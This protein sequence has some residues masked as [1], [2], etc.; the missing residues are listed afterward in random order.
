MRKQKIHSAPD[1]SDG[2]D[3]PGSFRGRINGA[4]RK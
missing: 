3:D 1:N 4:V 2:A